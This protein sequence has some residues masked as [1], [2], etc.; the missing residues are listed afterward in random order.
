MRSRRPTHV[1]TNTLAE[2]RL[3]CGDVKMLLGENMRA[4]LQSKVAQ[5]LS[6]GYKLVP[7]ASVSVYSGWQMKGR[8]WKGNLPL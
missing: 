8:Q 5:S 1:G 4:H 3:Q 2:V 6:Q 7:R